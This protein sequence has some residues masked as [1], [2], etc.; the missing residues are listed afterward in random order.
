[1]FLAGVAPLSHCGNGCLDLLVM[2]SIGRMRLLRYL[3]G[4]SRGHGAQQVTDLQ[5][6]VPYIQPFEFVFFRPWEL[7]WSHVARMS[8]NSMQ[9]PQV[10]IEVGRWRHFGIAMERL[11]GNQISMSSE[12]SSCLCAVTSS[13]ESAA[14]LPKIIWVFHAGALVSVVC[15]SG[16]LKRP[17]HWIWFVDVVRK[18]LSDAYGCRTFF[19]PDQWL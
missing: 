18:G 7:I 4:T 9:K 2:K 13:R 6:L 1:M 3:V 16:S 14:G 5:K 12:W 8:W 15:F 11:F 17:L 10:R 19:T